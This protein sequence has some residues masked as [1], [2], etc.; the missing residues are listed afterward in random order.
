MLQTVLRVGIVAATFLA[1][2]LSGGAAYLFAA[3][4]VYN[5]L[6]EASSVRFLAA[7]IIVMLVVLAPLLQAIVS[8]V[9]VGGGS[10]LARTVR[11]FTYGGLIAALA[12]A[13]V[14]A[15]AGQVEFV[16]SVRGALPL[17]WF[18]V[19]VAVWVAAGV[20]LSSLG[21]WPAAQ[22]VGGESGA[23]SSGG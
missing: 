1:A 18:S 4:V 22:D 11:G 5:R 2:W 12:A 14:G 23:S 7:S 19:S 8:T 9:L 15:L 6:V 13:L 3:R 17:V 21:L 20:V 16:A 10:R